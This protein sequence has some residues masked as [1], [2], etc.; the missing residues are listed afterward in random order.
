MLN[1]NEKKLIVAL[2]KQDSQNIM[3][4]SK[5]QEIPKSTLYDIKHRLQRAG[6]IKQVT[7]ISFEKIG[8]PIKAFFIIHTESEFKESLKKILMSHHNINNIILTNTS[9]F[10]VEGIFKNQIKVEEFLE[11]IKKYKQIVKVSTYH[12]VEHIQEEKFLTEE[13]HFE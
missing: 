7:K 1:T 3:N 12:V 5:K 2:R 4:V 8:F 9:R 11:E 6:I 10:H 13:E